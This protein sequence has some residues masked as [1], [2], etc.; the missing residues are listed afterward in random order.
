MGGD[1]GEHDVGDERVEKAPVLPV[2][3]AESSAPKGG[4]GVSNRREL[5]LGVWG[6]MEKEV[7]QVSGD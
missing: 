5:R 1:L 4:N 6:R 3:V 2:W 7:E